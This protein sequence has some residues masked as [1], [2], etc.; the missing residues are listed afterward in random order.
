VKVIPEIMI[1]L[2]GSVEELQNQK[3]IVVAVA[4]QV[5]EKAGMRV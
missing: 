1:P 5:F 4:E 2:I 3:K